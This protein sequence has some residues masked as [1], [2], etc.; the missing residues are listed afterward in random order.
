MTYQTTYTPYATAPE[1]STDG[2]EL[3]FGF[4]HSTAAVANIAT[5]TNLNDSGAGSLREALAGATPVTIRFAPGLAG[6]ITLASTATVSANTQ[7]DLTGAGAITIEGQPLDITGGLNVLSDAVAKLTINSALTGAGGIAKTGA[8]TLELGGTNTLTGA[9]SVSNGTVALVNGNAIDNASAVTVASGATLALAGGGETI[10]SLAGS[11]NVS[12]GAYTLTIGADN[13]STTFS[14]VISSIGSGIVKTG[15]GTL[16]LSGTNA[17]TGSTTVNGGTLALS[18]GAA[19]ADASAV[20]VA[21]GASLTLNASETLGSLAGAGT[22][23]LGSHT[24]TA[25]GSNT[26]TTFS[27][28]LVGSGQL[29]KAGT[30][31]LTLSGSNSGVFGGTIGVASGTLSVSGDGNLGAGTI[32]VNNGAILALTG[33]STIDNAIAVSGTATIQVATGINA[34]LEGSVTG[35]GSTL[36]K[37]GAGSLTL[38]SNGGSVEATTVSSGTLVVDGTLANTA[39]VSVSSGATLAGSGTVATAGAVNVASGGTLSPGNGGAGKLTITGNLS[40]APGAT[41]AVD[42]NGTTAG[43]QYDQVA[44]TGTVS[45]NGAT[46]SATHGYTPGMGDIYRLIDND[47][48]DSITGSFAGLAESATLTA[49]GNGTSLKGSYLGGTGNDFTLT[50]PV[51]P[52]VT[53]IVREGGAAQVTNAT[54]V[55]YTVSFSQAVSGVDASDFSVSGVAGTVGTVTDTGAGTTY[56]VT[57]NDATAEGSMRLDLKGSGTGIATTVG[58]LAIA[59]GYAI[60]EF[61]NLDHVA[62]TTTVDSIVFGTDTGGSSTDLITS[63]EGQL[64]SGTLGS[65]NELFDKVQVSVNNGTSWTDVTVAEGA[66]TWSLSNIPLMPGS[67]TVKVRVTDQAGN[68]GPELSRTYVR[69]STAPALASASVNG[70]AL[71]LRYTDTVQLDA[72][73]K[74][75]TSAFAVTVAGLSVAVNSVA[76]DAT[77]KTVTLTLA[78]AAQPGQAVTVAYTDPTGGNDANATQDMAGN[79]AASFAAMAATNDTAA[80]DPGTSTPPPATVDG[81]PVTTT[82][83]TNGATVITVP[84]VPSTRPDTPGTPYPTL[85][86][87][88]LA[89]D[90]SGQ[91]LLQ[92]GVPTGM[93]LAAEGLPTAPTGTAAQAELMQRIERLAGT[94]SELGPQAQAFLATLGTTEPLTVQTLK[95]TVGTGFNPAVP[96]VITGGSGQQAIVIDTSALPPGTMI[97]VD[98]VEFIAIVGAVRVIGGAGQNLASADGSAQW[99]VLGPGN[100]TIHGGAGNDTVGSEGGDDQV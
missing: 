80:P 40:L 5:V 79:D 58:N 88:P 65:D 19:I 83:G 87:I 84:V 11:G 27:G 94:G 68:H 93:G 90:G 28:A 25:G 61:Y 29:A 12:L 95:P 75:P 89:K 24:L 18:G 26:S 36:A 54:S 20:T 23:N 50:A 21:S 63:A 51:A 30:G 41:L 47:V 6:T 59:S 99:I 10:G 16:T 92:A 82:P 35:A 13:T 78:S 76:V 60:G 52:T 46:L 43:T 8:G 34:R 1:A 91:S 81:V 74:A 7:F 98:N 55:K 45:V 96:L 70:S 44:V 49:G 72:V 66:T 71:T 22:A 39:S 33:N 17:Y 15:S 73:N 57:V 9:V 2:Q 86:D 48:T 32:T 62:P 4:F 64:I 3:F 42:I 38:T 53:S 31:T 14:G 85:A 56:T 67:N 37:T 77:A 97:Q 100:D 69:D